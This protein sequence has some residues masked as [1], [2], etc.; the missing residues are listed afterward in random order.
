MGVPFSF[1]N[2]TG[3]IDLHRGISERQNESRVESFTIL[4]CDFSEFETSKIE[5]SL[6]QVIRTSDSYVHNDKHFFFVLYETDKHGANVVNSMF[7]EF[8]G[9]E[10]NHELVS[11]PRDGDTAQELF[12]ALQTRVKKKFDIYL[13]CLDHSSRQKPTY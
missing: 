7:E 3:L 10:I 9:T 5:A 8:F 12:D 4:F 2:L 1:Y 6:E 11:F 13:E